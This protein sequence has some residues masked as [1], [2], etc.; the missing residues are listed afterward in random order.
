MPASCQAGQASCLPGRASGLEAW[1]GRVDLHRPVGF[2]HLQPGQRGQRA[3]EPMGEGRAVERERRAVT[4]ADQ[5][6]GAGGQ[7]QPAALVGAD[8]GCGTQLAADASR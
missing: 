6:G 7:G 5:P 2:A 8:A 1:G 3:G 4:G